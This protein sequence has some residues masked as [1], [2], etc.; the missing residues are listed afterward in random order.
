MTIHLTLDELDDYEIEFT[1]DDTAADSLT[2]VDWMIQ[3]TVGM[4]DW[5]GLTD[6]EKEVLDD[7][8]QDLKLLYELLEDR[9]QREAV[10]EIDTEAI[11][12][13]LDRI[14]ELSGGV[15]HELADVYQTAD[16]IGWPNPNPYSIADEQMSFAEDA[17]AD[18]IRLGE[19][20]DSSDAGRLGWWLENVM[21]ANN[22]RDEIIPPQKMA[23]ETLVS[24]DRLSTF[25]DGEAQPT[26]DEL[27]SIL[28]WLVEAE[29][30]KPEE[31]EKVLD[32][33]GY[34][35]ASEYPF[36]KRGSNK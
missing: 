28:K 2:A 36:V 14:A 4:Y 22:Q 29:Y 12:N 33:L 34:V 35:D 18:I 7:A 26:G 15:M 16:R 9:Q 11:A 13:S 31:A 21:S 10:D 6:E 8:E 1:H 19:S 5:S 30:I 24:K 25:I 32:D 17:A 20:D 23:D 27:P 3:Q